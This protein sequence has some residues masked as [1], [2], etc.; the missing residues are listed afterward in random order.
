MPTLLTHGAAT[1]WS[2]DSQYLY[3]TELGSVSVIV[4]FRRTDGRRE[5]LADGAGAQETA[6]GSRIL[7]SKLDRPGI[8][9]RSLAGDIASNP[10]ERLVE[11]YGLPPSAALQPVVGGFYYAS[12]S[13][14][15]RARALRFYD[16]VQR[17]ARDIALLPGDADLVWG[18]TVSPDG[19]ELLFGAA[20][21]GADIVLLEFAESSA[22]PSVR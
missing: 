22:P 8:Y 2:R 3:V 9:T 10:E 4:R 19:R 20:R 12:Y 18:V 17:T 14:A 21:S 11:D 5:R 15:G 13:S 6:D 7:Y 16:D 1:G